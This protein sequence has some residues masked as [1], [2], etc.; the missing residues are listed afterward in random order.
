MH[1]VKGLFFNFLVVFFANYLL[2]GVRFVDQTKLP[3][4]SSDLLTPLILGA[5]NSFI[6]VFLRLVRRPP[7]LA[8]I[9]G[10]AL[11]FNFGAYALFKLLPFLGIL[12]TEWK[13]Y[14]FA[15]SVCSVGAFVV[16]YFEWKGKQ[17]DQNPPGPDFLQNT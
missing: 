2:P 11:V 15:A 6:F 14:L 13:G 3:H 9:G 7:T 4:I 1:Y 17:K 12:V 16:N 8:R 5:L 10:A